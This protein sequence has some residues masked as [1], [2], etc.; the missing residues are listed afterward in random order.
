M[1]TNPDA[2]TSGYFCLFMAHL[3]EIMRE[4][5]SIAEEIGGAWLALDIYLESWDV[6]L[7][8]R[9]RDVLIKVQEAYAKLEKYEICADIQKYL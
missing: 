3:K 2:P 9:G 1:L 6:I 8:A 4:T 5:K 7:K